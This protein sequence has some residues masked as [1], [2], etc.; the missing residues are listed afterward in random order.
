MPERTLTHVTS[1]TPRPPHGR[2]VQLRLKGTYG[3]GMEVH[4]LRSGSTS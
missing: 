2:V 1:Y 4:G 3:L